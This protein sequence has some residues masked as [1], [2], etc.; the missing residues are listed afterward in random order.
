MFQHTEVLPEHPVWIRDS[1]RVPFVLTLLLAAALSAHAQIVIDTF[2]GGAVR[3]G[4]PA[5]N[6]LL[7]N[8]SGVTWSPAGDVVF[9]DQTN[10]VIRRVRSDG[11]LETI[12]GKGVPGFTG[13]GG[14]ATNA[15]L[16]NPLAPHYDA[17]GNLY[18]ADT[19]NS[20]IR[21]V[22]TKGIITT[23]AGDGISYFDGLD[24]NGPALQ[25]SLPA[26]VDLQVSAS[27]N[28]YFLETV[29]SVS[30]AQNRIRLVTSDGRMQ[31]LTNLPVGQYSSRLAIDGAGN[32][33]TS[34]TNGLN[35][36]AILRISPDATVSVAYQQMTTGRASASLPGQDMTADVAGNLYFIQSQGIS[37]AIVRLNPDGSTTT[38][39]GGGQPPD[40]GYV[41]SPDGPAQPSVLYPSQ[42]VFNAHG[43]IAFVDQFTPLVCCNVRTEIREVSTASK[44]VTFAGANGQF[45]PDGTPLRDIW[46]E[47]LQSI[48]FSKS[49]D[50]YI[51]ESRA[52]MIRKIAADG[53]FTTFAGNGSCGYPAPGPNARNAAIP[54][55]VSIAVDSGNRVWVADGYADLYNIAPDGTVSQVIKTPVI[56]GTG[57]IAIDSKDR[58]DVVGIDSLYRVLPDFTFKQLT[59][60]PSAGGGGST[61]SAIGA[62]PSGAVYV[63]ANGSIYSI[64]EDGSLSL[65][66]SNQGYPPSLAVGSDHRIWEGGSGFIE[67]VSPAGS[68]VVGDPRAVT[69]GDGG[70]ANSA[71]VDAANWMVFSPAGDL[72]FTDGDRIRR[73]TGVGK[74][75]AAPSIQAGGIVNAAS[76]AG[77]AVAPGELISIFGSNFGAASLVAASPENNFFAFGVGRTQVLFNGS[78]GVITALAPNQINVIVPYQLASSTTASI[79]VEVDANLSLPVTVPIATAAPA[80]FTANASGSGQGSIVNEDGTVNSSANPAARGSIVSLYGTGLGALSLTIP[81]GALTISTPYPIPQGPVAVTIGGQP[82][83]VLYAGAAPFLVNGVFQINVRVPTGIAAGNAPVAASAGGVGPPQNVT[84][85]VK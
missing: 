73:V 80:V 71:A 21:R 56:G 63:A 9:C 65:A 14:P 52:C 62:D 82:A 38:I 60:T 24:S 6:V 55:P 78:P 8:I 54:P 32:L 43:D 76:Y 50:L 7:D 4:V 53:T 45:A 79:Q 27:G 84:V 39:A 77:G 41:S 42:M 83:E 22:D 20:R 16:K 44:L 36:A 58:V 72:Y 81:A 75:S 46:F 40:F 12:A 59:P 17:A 15:L 33:Y 26:I 2:A 51:A 11:I 30:P 10:Q 37:S 47:G 57:K 23:V 70:P 49:G 31:V 61:L 48:A 66:Y 64:N 35:Y 85:A 74:A 3:S 67:L 18:F 1:M 69:P 29:F 5:Q 34:L 28:I 68:A 25:R 19:G 13:D